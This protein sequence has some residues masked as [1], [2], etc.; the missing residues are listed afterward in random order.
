MQFFQ[1]RYLSAERARNNWLTAATK[2]SPGINHLDDD[3]VDHL[4][5]SI[6]SQKT[7]CSDA[8]DFIFDSSNLNPENLKEV[9]KEDEDNPGTI[10][11]GFS[12]KLPGQG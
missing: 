2:I 10:T 6:S 7:I 11:K 12:Y 4:A 8:F 9:E 3:E 5:A 1:Y